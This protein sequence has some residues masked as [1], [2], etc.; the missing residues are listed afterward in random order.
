[1]TAEPKDKEP[2]LNPLKSMAPLQPQS[3]KQAITKSPLKPTDG[4]L[5]KTSRPDE[6][7]LSMQRREPEEEF[8]MLSVLALK[9]IHTEEYREVDYVYEISAQKLFT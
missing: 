2:Q 3:D 5:Q 9:M 4:P 6:N 1:M 7:L 8:F